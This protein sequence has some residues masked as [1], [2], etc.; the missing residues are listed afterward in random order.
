MRASLP[1]GLEVKT[2]AMFL[3]MK[4]SRNPVNP[5]NLVNLVNWLVNLRKSLCNTC[6]SSTPSLFVHNWP[7]S[8]DHFKLCSH[9]WFPTTTSSWTALAPDATP[10]SLPFLS[11]AVE[12]SHGPFPRRDMGY[13]VSTPM[14]T[15]GS[16]PQF[17]GF[18][19]FTKFPRNGALPGSGF[20]CF[21][22]GGKLVNFLIGI[23]PDWFPPK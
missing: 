14:L 13:W 9:H 10:V 23:A 19:R 22:Q 11:A 20:F 7:T 18:T 6:V 17:T 16:S 12:E 2:V 15:R 5:V 1:P 8:N 4:L 21:K 3:A